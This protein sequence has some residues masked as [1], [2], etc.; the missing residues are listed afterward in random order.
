MPR[1]GGGGVGRGGG[2]V[3][4]IAGGFDDHCGI[5]WRNE[6][7]SEAVRTEAEV[8]VIDDCERRRDWKIALDEPACAVELTHR[9]CAAGAN[10]RAG[11]KLELADGQP[12]ASRNAL[13]D[14]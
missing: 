11:L 3:Q 2:P 4:E 6:V 8:S 12:P 14:A 10:R 7:E 13:A 1:A 9:Y 5:S